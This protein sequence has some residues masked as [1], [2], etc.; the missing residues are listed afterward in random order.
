VQTLRD[1]ISAALTESPPERR[2]PLGVGIPVG[3][4]GS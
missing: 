1:A 3:G 2:A 4:R